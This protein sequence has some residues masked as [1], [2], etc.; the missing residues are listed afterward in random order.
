MPPPFLLG[1]WAEPLTKFSKE[2][3]GGLAGPQLLFR[4]G[5]KERGDSFQGDGLQFLHK[6]YF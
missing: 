2:G 5:G 6:K 3:E 4:N 1:G